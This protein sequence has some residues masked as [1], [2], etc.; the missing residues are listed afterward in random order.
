MISLCECIK[1]ICPDIQLDLFKHGV[2]RYEEFN[3][4]MQYKQTVNDV[5]SIMLHIHALFL[6]TFS[7][8]LVQQD[9]S[10]RTQRRL[11]SLLR[12][13]PGHDSSGVLPDAL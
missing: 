9:S 8:Q 4:Y 11:Q 5:S 1:E 3:W 2:L 10:V 13:S 7:K 12:Q 6:F